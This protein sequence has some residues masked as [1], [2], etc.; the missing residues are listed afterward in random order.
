MVISTLAKNNITTVESVTCPLSFSSTSSLRVLFI[1]LVLITHGKP[2]SRDGAS[3]GKRRLWYPG[4]YL[5]LMLLRPGVTRCLC[6][7]S[8]FVF[9]FFFFFPLFTSSAVKLVKFRSLFPALLVAPCTCGL[10]FTPN[11]PWYIQLVF[12][13][14]YL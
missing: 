14:F 1:G 2:G 10:S 7:Y 3:A 11:H 6:R 5:P 13:F 9:L 8:L 4:S 12:S